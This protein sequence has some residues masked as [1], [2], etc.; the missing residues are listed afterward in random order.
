MLKRPLAIDPERWPAED[1]DWLRSDVTEL[2]RLAKR[3][4]VVLAMQKFLSY[5][6]PKRRT[7]RRKKIEVKSTMTHDSKKIAGE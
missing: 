1:Y 3:S 2:E 7:G 5:I 4:L 6:R